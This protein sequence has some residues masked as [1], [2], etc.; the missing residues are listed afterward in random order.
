LLF[1]GTRLN[2][3]NMLG[4][5]YASAIDIDLFLGANPLIDAV[6]YWEHITAPVPNFP[7]FNQL[8]F[9]IGDISAYNQGS[10]GVMA[11]NG[12]TVPTQFMA[13]GQ[14]FGVKALGAGPATFTNAMRVETP[15]TDYRNN[16]SDR[17]RIW[18]DLKNE[19]YNLKSNML[20]AFTEG[21]T[22]GFEGLYDSRRFD[23]SIS[24]YSVLDTD[25][26][27]CIQGRTAFNEEQIVDL[28]FS[29]MVKEL[30]TYTISIHQIE[31]VDIS[32]ATVY[33]ED[34]L[35]NISTNLSDG[36]YTFT[37]EEGQQ[38][39]RFKLVFQERVLSNND[40]ALENISMLPN[41]TTGMLVV[42]SPM[43]GVQQIE[44]IDVQGRIISS[45]QYDSANQYLVD[46]SNLESA[47]YFVKLYT[48]E[49]TLI[50]RVIRK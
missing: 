46:L 8:N 3:P 42:N 12:T 1:N 48:S 4:N 16:N 27:L 35:L 30:Q 19:T 34:H 45:K 7:G 22:D 6:Y 15:N 44:V 18:L 10:G 24:L 21:A 9:N 29:T 13:S 37:S 2:S 17:Q 49:G 41:P 32:N 20:V 14:G 31:G 39:N 28:G 43:A 47:M 11:P 26:Q 23:S 40:V 25:E 36:N 50:K 5:P 33:L 38:L